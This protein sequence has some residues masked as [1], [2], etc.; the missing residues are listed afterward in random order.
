RPPRTEKPLRTFS[1]GNQQKAVIAKFTRLSPKLLVVDEP[2]QGVDVGG[3]REIALVLRQFTEDGGTVLLASSDYDEISTLCA[4]VI[5]LN[6]GRLI[7]I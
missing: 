6:R 3:K 2:T 4:R 7:G 5:V 1:G